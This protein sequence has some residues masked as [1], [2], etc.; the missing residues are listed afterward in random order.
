M[1]LRPRLRHNALDRRFH[2][3]DDLLGLAG[4]APLT[5][6]WAAEHHLPP[7]EW[8]VPIAIGQALKA[9]DDD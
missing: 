1:R 9:A 6:A 2:A 8:T 4:S 7:E 5:V 3:G